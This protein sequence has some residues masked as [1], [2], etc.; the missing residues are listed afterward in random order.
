MRVVARDGHI[1]FANRLLQ[2]QLAVRSGHALLGRAQVR[3]ILQGFQLQ[4]IEIDLHR[5]VFKRADNVVIRRHRLVSQQLPQVR[6]R[7]DSSQLG[8][9][10]V[11]FE[12]QQLQLDHQ[13]VVLTEAA[14]LVLSLADVNGLLK[15]LQILLGKLERRFGK[16]GTV[17]Q[18][19]NL[20]RKTA[21]VIR[22]QRFCL[23]G[24]VLLRLQAVMALSATFNQ[25]AEAD[26]AFGVVVQIIGC[27][28]S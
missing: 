9:F 3:A 21:P 18:G 5:L 15:A 19:S 11:A 28:H 12:L 10:F 26:V 20:K 22:H 24:D 2:Y 7:L 23:G 16:L 8:L 4:V 6:Q 25:I 13:I 1:L 14:G 27:R 17:K